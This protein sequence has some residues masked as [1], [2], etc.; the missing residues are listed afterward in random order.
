[1][2]CKNLLICLIILSLFSCSGKRFYKILNSEPQKP[3]LQNY[4]N[5]HIGW[6]PFNENEWKTYNYESQKDWIRVIRHENIDQLQQ[7]VKQYLPK[8]HIT[9]AK[10]KD[11]TIIPN[12]TEL[13]IKF[14]SIQITDYARSGIINVEFI[15]AKTLAV[16]YKISSEIYIQGDWFG[17]EA[18]LMNLMYYIGN[19]LEFQF[20]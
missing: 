8:K 1:M 2:K 19:F 20:R 12:Q 7:Y 4:N 11:D 18:N 13:I 10:S 5:I 16:V 3:N 15:N 6:L 14:T 9:G 17:F